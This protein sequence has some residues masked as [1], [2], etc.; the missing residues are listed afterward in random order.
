MCLVL[1]SFFSGVNVISVV[2]CSGSKGRRTTGRNNTSLDTSPLLYGREGGE[3]ESCLN[4]VEIKSVRDLIRVF[5]RSR[6]VL[7]RFC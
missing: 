1:L 7:V 6:D 5:Q 2:L 4:I 3:G